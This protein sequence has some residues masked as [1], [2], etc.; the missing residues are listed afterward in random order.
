MGE[1]LAA[2]LEELAVRV[3]RA[4]DGERGAA[5][6]TPRPR[7]ADAEPGM[8]ERLEGRIP[9]GTRHVQLLLERPHVL[10]EPAPPERPPS[11]IPRVL[12]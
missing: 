9:V 11:S 4:P 2:P 8:G 6:P 10:G 1:L 3:L 12:P 7:V 5:A